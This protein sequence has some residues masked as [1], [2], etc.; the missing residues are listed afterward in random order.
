MVWQQGPT[1]VITLSPVSTSSLYAV[2]TPSNMGV[3]APYIYMEFYPSL[4]SDSI[5]EVR[6]E[7]QEGRLS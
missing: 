4:G 1:Q 5:I 7:G 2:F 3:G 6:K